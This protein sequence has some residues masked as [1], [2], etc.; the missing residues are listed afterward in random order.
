[1][2]IIKKTAEGKVFVGRGESYLSKRIDAIYAYIVKQS[3]KMN[4]DYLMTTQEV[5]EKLNYQRTNVSKDLNDLVRAGKLVKIGGRPVR[6]RLA[7]QVSEEAPSV[8]LPMSNVKMVAPA[9]VKEFF[10]QREKDDVFIHLI[11]S[12]GSLKMLSNKRKLR[13]Y[14][15][16]KG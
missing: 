13:F 7:G 3:K 8:V 9:P 5:S 1:M 2:V 6:Y 4:G 14:T 15:L 11:G 12:R 16:Q 10:N